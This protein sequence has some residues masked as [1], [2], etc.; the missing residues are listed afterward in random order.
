MKRLQ[1]TILALILITSPSLQAATKNVFLGKTL[2]APKNEIC[3]NGSMDFYYFK[4]LM[5]FHGRVKKTTSPG[6]L[7]IKLKGTT[8]KH[9]TFNIAVKANLEGRY[10][11]LFN[12]E[13]RRYKRIKNRR[14]IKWSI[15]SVSYR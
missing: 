6:T 14:D 1:T 7:K 3:I 10:S 11:E 5:Q 15:Q 2:C 13:S 12:V 8:T 4:G 9:E